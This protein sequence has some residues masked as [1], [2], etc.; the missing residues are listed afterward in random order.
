MAPSFQSLKSQQFP[1]RSSINY[2]EANC[3]TVCY[4]RHSHG[5]AE[6]IA[7]WRSAQRSSASSIP[8][9]SR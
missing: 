5:A 9:L 1:Q 4:R 3:K 2:A 8:T 7:E 6:R